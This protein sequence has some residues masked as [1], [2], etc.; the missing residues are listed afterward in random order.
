MNREIKFRIWAGKQFYYKCLVGNTNDTDDKKYTCPV[1]WID[2]RKEWNSAVEV[3]EKMG[4]SRTSIS[5]CVR[6]KNKTA[7]GFKWLFKE[8]FEYM[9]YRIGE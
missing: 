6:G 9:E 7:G 2:D 5:Q 8:Q 4:I 3:E 1:V